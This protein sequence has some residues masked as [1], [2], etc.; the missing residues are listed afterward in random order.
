MVSIYSFAQNTYPWPSNASVGIGTSSPLSLFQVVVPFSKSSTSSNST[1]AGIA[2]FL[3]TND[4]SAPFGLRTMIYGAPAIGGRFV[5]LQTTDYN[6]IDGGNIILQPAVGHVGIGTISPQSVLDVSGTVRVNG[7]NS[8]LD[9]R[10]PTVGNLSSLA[11]TGQMLMGWNRA[12][13]SGEAD[14]IGNQGQGN[15]D[16]FAFWNHDNSNNEQMLMWILGNGQVLIGDTRGKQG[17]YKLV[18]AGSA[19]ATSITVKTVDQWP[20]YVFKDD[21]ELP[22]LSDVKSYIDKNHHLSDVLSEEEV[23]KGGID[24]GGMNAT[25]LKKVEE[26]TF[27][28]IEQNKQLQEL[29]KEVSE[30]KEKQ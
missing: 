12:G 11:R 14:F 8:N 10:I 2:S 6:S 3:S 30:L 17:S 18:I 19:I 9:A 1:T 27:Y 15:T 29:K 5:T 25:L 28:L 24:L 21:Y 16:G 23:K 7:N 22:K 26:L 20:D 4:A 13:G